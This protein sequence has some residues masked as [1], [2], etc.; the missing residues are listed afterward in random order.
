MR[1][2]W[3]SISGRTTQCFVNLS[4]PAR[5]ICFLSNRA[6][7]QFIFHLIY[8]YLFSLFLEASQKECVVK[9]SGREIVLKFINQNCWVKNNEVLEQPRNCHYLAIFNMQFWMWVHKSP[10]VLEL[11][12]SQVGCW[13]SVCSIDTQYWCE[14]L[15]HIYWLNLCGSM[16]P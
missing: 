1:Q 3:F 12:K 2:Q 7:P 16:S 4:M 13:R 10:R 6:D 11:D 14:V 8:L 9:G 5:I 15:W